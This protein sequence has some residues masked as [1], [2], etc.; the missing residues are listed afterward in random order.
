MA[1]IDPE[2]FSNLMFKK[3]TSLEGKTVHQILYQDF[4]YYNLGKYKIG[5]GQINTT[6]TESIRE[7]EADLVEYMKKICLDNDYNL[8]MLMVTDIISEASEV[9]FAGKD[10]T[11]LAKAFGL[12]LGEN[13]VILPGVVSRKK[14]I[15][16]NMAHAASM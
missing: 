16:P 7:Q 11:L 15:V 10:K 9:F 2:E 12:E 14:Q 4:K 5:I 1:A 6:D 3:G 8:L 13:S